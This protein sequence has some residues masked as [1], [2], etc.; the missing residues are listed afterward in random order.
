MRLKQYIT[1]MAMPRDLDLKKTYY[2]GTDSEKA[3]KGILRKG[4]SPPDL[5]T[6]KGLLRPVE[7]KVYI[8]TNLEYAT[9]YAIG[10]NM[11]G[12]D[13]DHI[14]WNKKEPTAY[15]FVIYGKQLKDIQPDEDS[16]GEMIYNQNPEW[17]HRLATSHLAS[18]TMM[19]IMD[20]EYAYWAKAG[21]VLNKKMTDQQKLNLI[22]AGAH[23]AHTGALK[24]KEA[25]AMPKLD[26]RLLKKDASNFFKVAKRMKR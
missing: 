6:R 10:A 26:N 21:K 7:G 25:W 12:S 24:P 16:I 15:I 2:H 19:K 8:T 14:F 9:I 11:V 20:G 5:T 4:I 23:I 1:E 3:A 17:L 22:D 18:S 13:T